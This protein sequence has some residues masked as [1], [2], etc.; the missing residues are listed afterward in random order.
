MLLVSNNY[1]VKYNVRDL[2]RTYYNYNSW[3]FEV[4]DEEC[5]G[6]GCEMQEEEDRGAKRYHEEDED[7]VHNEAK[8]KWRR[9]EVDNATMR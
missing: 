4:E 6:G 2:K 3:A 1:L 7:A 5:R 8:R 9:K